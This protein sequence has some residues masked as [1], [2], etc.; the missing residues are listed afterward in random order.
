MQVFAI[1]DVEIDQD[2]R[3]ISSCKET[4]RHLLSETSSISCQGLQTDESGSESEIE[5]KELTLLLES[6]S[7]GQIVDQKLLENYFLPDAEEPAPDKASLTSDHQEETNLQTASISKASRARSR[8][9]P[10]SAHASLTPKKGTTYSVK[11]STHVLQPRSR[12][13]N[14]SSRRLRTRLSS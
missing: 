5:M 6:F 12:S 14:N 3:K 1:K 10:V 11:A 4:E 8:S 9:H 7:S 13:A 2:V